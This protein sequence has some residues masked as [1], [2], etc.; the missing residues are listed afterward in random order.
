MKIRSNVRL[1][2]VMHKIDFLTGSV[3]GQGHSSRSKVILCFFSVPC[4]SQTTGKNFMECRSNVHL[5]KPIL[6]IYLESG[7][8]QCQGHS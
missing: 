8:V 5:I 2:E 4:N 7:L 1:T 3:Q 6:K